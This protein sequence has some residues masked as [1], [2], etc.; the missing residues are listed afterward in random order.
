LN[1][2]TVPHAEVPYDHGGNAGVAIIAEQEC[3]RIKLINF[4]PIANGRWPVRQNRYRCSNTGAEPL[5]K[6]R[7][8]LRTAKNK[9][10]KE[11]KELK[12]MGIQVS[13]NVATKTDI[14]CSMK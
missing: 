2:H 11:F 1:Q 6:H 5:K 3:F 9:N 8:S 4:S 14:R 7:W 10:S 13:H 12:M